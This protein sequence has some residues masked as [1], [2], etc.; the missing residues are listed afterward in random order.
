MLDEK[1]VA[2]FIDELYLQLE[3]I[4]AG[5]DIL[6]LSDLSCLESH[7]IYAFCSGLERAN[8]EYWK[9]AKEFFPGYATHLSRERDAMILE[10]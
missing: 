7:S 1:K 8:M 6:S 3:F 2:E 5:L 10:K 9:R 4:N